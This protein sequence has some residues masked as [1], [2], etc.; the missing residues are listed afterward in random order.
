M[1]STDYIWTLIKQGGLTKEFSLYEMVL[2]M[3]K[4]RVAICQT[5]QQYGFVYYSAIQLLENAVA[6]L[7]QRME[8]SSDTLYENIPISAKTSVS[9]RSSMKS[10]EDVRLVDIE[11]FKPD[12]TFKPEPASIY[13]KPDESVYDALVESPFY[14]NLDQTSHL[15][16][17]QTS[18][19]TTLNERPQRPTSLPPKPKLRLSVSDHS[20]S[21]AGTP[22]EP[23][24]A[25]VDKGHSRH[26]LTPDPSDDSPPP[27]PPPLPE[28]PRTGHVYEDVECHPVGPF[29]PN[30]TYEDLILHQHPP[31]PGR[32]H[33]QHPPS[34]GRPH[35][36]LPPE[37]PSPRQESTYEEISEDT[38]SDVTDNALKKPD[39]SEEEDI[40]ETIG[41]DSPAELSVTELRTRNDVRGASLNRMSGLTKSKLRGF[42]GFLS[43]TK[44]K[45][46]D[47][48][49]A[50]SRRVNSPKVTDHH[51][52]QTSISSAVPDWEFGKRVAKP[53]GPRPEPTHW[54]KI[55]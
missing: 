11:V 54:I 16:T 55:K 14:R 35:S 36:Q 10:E 19:Y 29:K 44:D 13:T 34:P 31:S 40:Y 18:H 26:S 50:Q 5:K 17:S 52:S 27:L 6:A 23:L 28:L 21:P 39:S 49:H 47:Q 24:Y 1:V 2:A 22:E 37:P 43:N 8:A 4:Q 20:P 53:R 30:S 12:T 32:P 51:N 7:D 25:I 38:F 46:A 48:A 3:R 9:S 33:S 15:P 41:N 42:K 45:L